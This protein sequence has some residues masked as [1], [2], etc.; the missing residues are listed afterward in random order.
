MV[1]AALSLLSS[2]GSASFQLSFQRGSSNRAKNLKRIPS[3]SS[4]DLLLNQQ[5]SLNMSRSISSNSKQ[6]HHDGSSVTQLSAASTSSNDSD[7]PRAPPSF[8]SSFVGTDA[9]IRRHLG[10]I[11]FAST[12][13]E[14]EGAASWNDGLDFEDFEPILNSDSNIGRFSL[15]EEDGERT[16][17][18]P[19]ASI[20][21]KD[22]M[23]KSLSIIANTNVYDAILPRKEKSLSDVSPNGEAEQLNADD[24]AAPSYHH[25]SPRFHF[26]IAEPRPSTSWRNLPSLD[27]VGVPG[28]HVDELDGQYG[29]TDNK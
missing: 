8:D 23:S 19:C 28:M 15:S 1:T 3:A 6:E 9:E 29:S 20:T 25:Q 5:G 21:S 10:T 18:P 13:S 16:S 7:S 11:S 26:L 24:S 22:S 27:V 12:E 14:D 17:S 2:S 4:I